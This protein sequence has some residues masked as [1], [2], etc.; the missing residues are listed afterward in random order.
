[1]TTRSGFKTISVIGLGYVGLPTA[2]TIATRGV[3]VIGVDTNAKVVERINAGTSHIEETDLDVV[4]QAAIAS[5]KLRAVV[6]PE[7]AD[8][9]VIAVPTPITPAKTSD[10]TAVEAAFRSIAPVLAKGNLVILES[11]SPVGTTERMTEL[12]A[13]LRPD[14]TFPL[15]HPNASDILVSYCP[16]RILPGQTLRELVDNSRTTGGLDQRSTERTIELYQIFCRGEMVATASRAAELVKLAENSFRDV[17]IAFANELSMLCADLDIDVHAVIAAANRH[18]RVN[19]LQPGPGV[20]GHCIPVDPWFIVEARPERARLIRTARE[21]NDSKTDFVYQQIR[22]RADRFKCANIAFLGLAYKPDVDDLRESPALEIVERAARDKLGHLM[23]VEPNIAELPA[24]LQ[25]H[26]IEFGPLDET[27]K[28][29]DVVVLL[30]AHKPFKSI[31][32]S[33]LAE[34]MVID[35]VGLFRNG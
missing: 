16:E 31:P 3:D 27:I 9:F 11:T 34:K 5:G 10:L 18:P 1:M 19:I 2:A 21:V 4:L 30:V 26:D 6:K 24:A 29:A 12:L 14:L 33:A 25:G 32:T 35:A 23:V 13:Q 7:P 15:T 17:N 28:K 8:A 20:G 22:A